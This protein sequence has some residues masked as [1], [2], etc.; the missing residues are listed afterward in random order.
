MALDAKLTAWQNDLIDMS[1]M[2]RLLYFSAETARGRASSVRF[3]LDPDAVFAQF[4][5]SRRAFVIKPEQTADAQE[6]ETRL[7]RLRTRAREAL[8][9]RGTH[10]L[11]LAFGLLEWRESESSEEIIR[12]PLLLLPVSLMRKGVVGAFQLVRQPAEEIEINPTLREKLLH[13]FHLTLP[14]F[15]SICDAW[16]QQERDERDFTLQH[17]FDAVTHAIPSAD[18][19]ATWRIAREVHLGAFSYQKLV[20]YQD[21]QRHKAELLAHPL[22]RVLGGDQRLPAQ[23]SALL[24]AEDL[25]TQVR[26]HDVLEI[27]D[28]D[29]SQQEAIAAAKAGA[30][31]VLQGPPGTGKS[32]TIA[33][34][35][36]ECVGQ[37]K[38][39]LFVS[40]K[41]AALEVVQQRLRD[42]GLGDYCLDLHSQK[43][44][45]KGFIAD[46]KQALADADAQ[47]T[48]SGRHDFTWQHEADILLE[49]RQR[50]NTY[51]REL[52][53]PRPLL[54]A[55]AFEAYARLAQL[56]AVPDM[57]VALPSGLHISLSELDT[58]REALRHLLI[59]AD[60]LD[61]IDAYPWRETPLDHYSLALAGSI[62]HHYERLAETLGQMESLGAQLRTTLDEED[63]PLTIGWLRGALDRAT[64]ITQTPL[65][66]HAWL[67]DSGETLARLR[68]HA[69]PAAQ[70]GTRFHAVRSQ[71]LDSYESAILDLDHTR[72]LEALTS[73]ADPAIACIRAESRLPQ[74][75]CIEER[76]LLEAHLRAAGDVVGTLGD[77]GTRLAS[78][79]ELEKPA[80]LGEM[81][82]LLEVADLLLSAP[83]VPAAWLDADTFAEVRAAALDARERYTSCQRT[84]AALETEYAPEFFVLDLP[85][86]ARRF[87]E[88]YGS[89]LRYL[90]PGY[91]GDIR[92]VRALLRG[93]G[94]ER[95]R[96]HEQVR[97]DILKGTKLLEE[98]H[99]LREHR[100]EHARL[101]GRLFAGDETDWQQVQ[102]H[103]EWAERFHAAY[104]GRASR[105]VVALL[106][107]PA[108]ALTPL[109]A[110]RDRLAHVWSEWQAEA[111]YFAGVLR[112]DALSADASAL[113]D[114]APETMR[115]ALAQLEQA[116]ER[117]WSAVDAVGGQR[118]GRSAPP[119]WAS[120]CAGLRLAQEARTLEAWLLEQSATLAADMGHF[121]AGLATDWDRVVAALAWA[122]SLRSLYG[123]QSIPE[124]VQHLLA[125]ETDNADTRAVRGRLF[126]ALEQ[127]RA[128]L[129][130][131]EDEL[132]F[133]DSVL[134]RT[135][136][137][138]SAHS[139]DEALVAALR[140]R[141]IY[142]LGKL[143]CLE[144]WIECSQ[145]RQLCVGLG[146]GELV[147]AALRER[148]FPRDIEDRFEKRFHQLWLDDVLRTAP[149]LQQFRGATHEQTIRR[150][151]QLDA[152]HIALA[153]K[154]L[155][156]QL[157]GR[158]HAQVVK[159][160]AETMGNIAAALGVLRHEVSK[161]RNRSIRQIVQSTAPALLALK[162]CW[163]MSPFSVS[164]FL[165]SGEQLFD[166][167][168]FDEASQVS[169]EDAICAI[170]RGKQL[171]IVGDLK[172]LPPTRFF[173]RTLADLERDE[174]DED[175]EDDAT[176]VG[177]QS[178]VDAGGAHRESIL[179]ECEAAD[180]P[181]YALRWHYRS[182]HESLIAFS[183]AHFYHDSLL[184]FPGPQ[185]EHSAGVRFEH[186]RE[187][188]Y[189]RSHS[190][191]NMREA[192]RVVELVIEHVQRWGTERSL[193]VVALSQAQQR[194][195]EDVLEGRLKS[196]LDLRSA[197]G[198]M[199]NDDNP[200]GFFI[201]NLESVQGDERDVII[202]S[203][204]Y[205]RDGTGK[206]SANFGPIN[207]G[208]GER[209]LNVAVTRARHQM[210][211]VSSMRA[212]E[213][214]KQL[215]SPG[216][217]ALRDYLEYAEKGPSALPAQ[218]QR[219]RTRSGEG[220]GGEPE[221]ESPFEL[222]VYNALKASGLLVDAQVGC[223]G[224][225][226][227]LAVRD[228]RQLDRYLLGIECDG[229]TYHSSATAR[230]RDRLRQRQLENL[231][232][233]IHRIWS[234][235]WVN[236]RTGALQRT[237]QAIEAAMVTA[238]EP[239][240]P[241]AVPSVDGPSATSASAATSDER[242]VAP[243]HQDQATRATQP[244]DDTVTQPAR[245]GRKPVVRD[246]DT[247]ITLPRAVSPREDVP[248]ASA[249][250]DAPDGRTP[251][252]PMEAPP[253]RVPRT[254]AP[255]SLPTVPRAAQRVCES[256][257]SFRARTATHFYCAHGATMRKRDASGYT[258]ACPAWRRA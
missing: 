93:D 128:Y 223:S 217:Q 233:T 130:T 156:A 28:A 179:E 31:F 134:A 45:K 200:A 13:D 3:L 64:L 139:L 243:A 161:K 129:L 85:A 255:R 185:A 122:D 9:D 50:L 245:H 124:G 125:E 76:P 46:L 221:F 157:A 18:V 66:P 175:A 19:T 180:L 2:N 12:S 107:G 176:Q 206:V 202:L 208:G 214:P 159:A 222:S 188:I 55:K 32:Q 88:A 29:S 155:R 244:D 41:M 252:A 238:N 235:D 105:E 52:H 191:Q 8:N 84:R 1:R 106:T 44:D 6:C 74:D 137:L 212:D 209:R 246:P 33:N 127:G 69:I 103:I 140:E 5:A 178:A 23:P 190:R 142:H 232:W 138:G 131:L 168:I 183:N 47:P 169:P 220:V 199:L 197:Y 132:R 97:I 226:I 239:P 81:S 250:P 72:L 102:A 153:R 113:D 49:T 99:W 120:L 251:P 148:P 211:V 182:R 173:T 89:L 16:E 231:G 75:R 34:V 165:E 213:M 133:S 38:R 37:G 242:A 216:A 77:A 61:Q 4:H 171:V 116:L 218:T 108:R 65:P 181:R 10:V 195:I 59:W 92:Q 115:T 83:Q 22:L 14:T 154:R 78:A 198:E 25:D 210:I 118:I 80:R 166:L 98:E 91:Y 119:A 256:C 215:A 110:A 201:K 114:L 187:G 35:I 87:D 7:A 43:T 219:A 62:R 147:Q 189:D 70:R 241:E 39:I 162:P 60:V 63:A 145:Q 236:D 248:G 51:V 109:R 205:A 150:F 54:Q 100:V 48:D 152:S 172:Q 141:V 254:T 36:A 68:L 15:K 123:E 144:R 56:V 149:A 26:P 94:T 237:L 58:M 224:Y 229:A 170:L 42:A 151:R 117:F 27:L 40:E 126:G 11:Y 21:L 194:A 258:Q 184:T 96:T 203:I 160:R 177:G 73:E 228:P 30:S 230:D 143:P 257:V 249:P 112:P 158:R 227:D 204:G 101:F 57:D 253:V 174:D 247:M 146:L 71:L 79:C 186:V 82:D 207:K 234:R 111:A 104:G 135:A 193:G 17:V 95:Q 136:L 121:G 164:Q 90:Q 225:R 240:A 24:R 20:M 196:D 53:A 167:V 86:L 163:L 192:R 67:T